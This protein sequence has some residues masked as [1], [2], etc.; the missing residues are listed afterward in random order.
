VI[1][2]R[3]EGLVR[4][5]EQEAADMVEKGNSITSDDEQKLQDESKAKCDALAAVCDEFKSVCSSN[6]GNADV[7]EQIKVVDSVL[8]DRK[9][10]LTGFCTSF[11]TFLKDEKNRQQVVVKGWVDEHIGEMRK[12]WSDHVIVYKEQAEAFAKEEVREERSE[13]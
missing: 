8:A 11:S 5:I 3:V 1:G 12:V 6:P 7:G 2:E 4:A 9:E 10:R 13:E